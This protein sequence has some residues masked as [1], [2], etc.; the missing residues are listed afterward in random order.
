MLNTPEIIRS[1]PGQTLV[2]LP[3]GV[4]RLWFNER[5]DVIA[6]LRGLPEAL[7]A[8][9]LPG[10]GAVGPRPNGRTLEL[11]GRGSTYVVDTG[12]VPGGPTFL[13][14]HSVA[15]TGML[16]WYPSLEMLRRLGRVVIFD[17]RGHG[18]G[19]PAGRVL[20][21]DCADDAVA[22]ADALGI[23]TVI[24]VG[25]SMG[26]LVA[27]LTWQRHR[28]R[29]DA[30]VLC[31][32]AATFAEAA[33]MRLGT[34]LFAALLDAFTPRPDPA[35]APVP[36]CDTATAND[37]RWA[38]AEFRATAVPGMLRA[39]AEIVR[40]DSRPWVNRIDVPTAVVVPTRD[41]VI[42]PRHQRW[43]AEQIPA[44][45]TVPVVGGHACCTLQQEAFVAG[46]RTAVTTVVD[47]LPAAAAAAAS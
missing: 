13:L 19:I 1:E 46:L 35:A 40:F 37:V 6:G 30:L 31:A 17:Q 27:Q 26:S 36:G 24:P 5:I 47:R 3:R 38:L 29:V 34:S 2:R 21:E 11:P 43:L 14:L 39:L 44:A 12:P 22:V 32:A 33:P 42:S 25:F 18:A 23:D 28:D 9:K 15:C 4:P 16:T 8:A 20:L 10:A 7:L 45:T 41:R